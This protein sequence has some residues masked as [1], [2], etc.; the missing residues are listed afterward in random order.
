VSRYQ[1]SGV[2]GAV[3]ESVESCQ[4]LSD[5]ARH[6]DCDGLHGLVVIDGHAQVLR[7]CV[8]HCDGV[9]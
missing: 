5:V 9:Q 2:I 1:V 8:I 7:S 6:A 4:H 3:E